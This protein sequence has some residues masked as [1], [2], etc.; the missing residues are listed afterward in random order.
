MKIVVGVMA[1]D[2]GDDALAFAEVLARS[3][4]AELLLAHIHPPA[5]RAYNQGKVDAEW[6]AFLTQQAHEAVERAASLF[7]AGLR[8]IEQ[9]VHTHS[10]SGRG[11][12]EVAEQAGAN[13]ILIGSSPGGVAGAI[14]GGSTSDQLLH[15][16]PVPVAIAP[17]G[18]RTRAPDHLGRITIAY[19]K[20][21]QTALAMAGAYGLARRCG[22]EVRL[23]TLIERPSRLFPGAA[24]SLDA[25]RLDAKHWLDDARA[26]APADV[27]VTV[28]ISEGDSMVEAIGATRFTDDDLVVVGSSSKGAVRRVFLGDTAHRIVRHSPAP[29]MVVPHDVAVDLDQTQSIPK[30]SG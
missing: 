17:E 23:L 6:A 20:D 29:V 15:G 26:A 27:V 8:G 21:H 24:R 18:Y 10:S 7:P 4:H 19:R 1:D 5:W 2:R 14:R 9:T 30:V 11:L 22:V 12:A 16:S 28:E 3:A 13:L 25:M